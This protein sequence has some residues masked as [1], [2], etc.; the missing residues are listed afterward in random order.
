MQAHSWHAV[1]MVFALVISNSAL[2]QRYPEKVVTLIVPYAA[3]AS[4][5]LTARALAK[6]LADD[7]KQPFIIE[8]KPG[9]DALVGTQLTARSAPDGYTILIAGG[10]TFVLNPH[11]Y[12]QLA[13]DPVRDFTPVSLLYRLTQVVVTGAT[14]SFNSLQDLVGQAK[15]SP[16]KLTFAASAATQRLIFEM[17]QQMTGTNMLYIPYKGAAAYLADTSTKVIDASAADVL[18][19]RGMID[20]GQLRGLGVTS[21][22]R[23]ALLPKVPTIDEAGLRGFEL[24]NWVGAWVPAA[25]SLV[26]STRLN[27]LFNRAAKSPALQKFIIDGG[28]ETLELNLTEFA[29]L[30]AADME[31]FGR[32]IKAAGIQAQ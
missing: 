25:T 13:Y 6:T 1:V 26:V 30:Q 9:V 29:A 22:S 28:G 2:A 7:T 27:E 18:S 10:S 21:K 4:T 5:D 16:G 8:N 14:S 23:H 3:G 20:A 32:A 24:T 11:L 19:V 31:K 17:I 12:K 15:Q